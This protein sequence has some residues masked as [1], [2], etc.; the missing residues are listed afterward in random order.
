MTGLRIP[1]AAAALLAAGCASTPGD[2]TGEAVSLRQCVSQSRISG[3]EALDPARVLIYGP[4]Q[5]DAWLA[6]I[7]AGCNG[8]DQR[9]TIA[10]V[11]GDRNGDICSFGGDSVAFRDGGRL[12][13]CAIRSLTELSPEGLEQIEVEHGL[14]KAPK[15]PAA[16]G[17]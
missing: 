15:Q 8:M 5:R 10:F 3:F 4:R 11:D 12:T 14:K 16:G 7:G 13:T 2:S 17:G 1:A 9:A 6:G